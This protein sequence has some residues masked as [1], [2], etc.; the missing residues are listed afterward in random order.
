MDRRRLEHAHFRFAAL[1][2]ASWY[3]NICEYAKFEFGDDATT[4][5]KLTTVYSQVF[6]DAY[7]GTL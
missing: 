3:P 1:N 7:S 2:V 4:L 5:V 6:H